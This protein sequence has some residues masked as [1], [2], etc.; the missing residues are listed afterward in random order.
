MVHGAAAP[1]PHLLP[2]RGV[3]GGGARRRRLSG[4]APKAGHLADAVDGLATRQLAL[5][6]SSGGGEPRRRVHLRRLGR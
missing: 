1:H 3:V 6:G 5:R 2:Q 4:Q